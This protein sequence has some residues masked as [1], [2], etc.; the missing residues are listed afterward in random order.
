[1]YDNWD[2]NVRR[3]R[4]ESIECVRHA[5]DLPTAAALGI[6]VIDNNT[7]FIEPCVYVPRSM[8]FLF[9]Y[10][11]LKLRSDASDHESLASE[12]TAWLERNPALSPD[13]V[14]PI[15]PSN[16]RNYLVRRKEAST[17]SDDVEPPLPE[18][19]RRANTW[20]N[21]ARK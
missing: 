11:P 5:L 10:E 14:I 7:G 8:R 9:M 20:S 2:Y 13:D 17:W 18:P 3:S 16:L 19:T 21:A 12:V 1:V 15:L 6:E 4:C